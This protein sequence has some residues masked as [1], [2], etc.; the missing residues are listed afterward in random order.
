MLV[1]AR[2]SSQKME[3]VLARAVVNGLWQGEPS[4][5][6]FFTVDIDL[7]EIG[8]VLKMWMFCSR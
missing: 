7:G 8:R 3:D 2:K 1:W 5:Q 4:N 6:V